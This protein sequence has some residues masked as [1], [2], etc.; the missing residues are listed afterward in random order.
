MGTAA[1]EDQAGTVLNRGFEPE[2][3]LGIPDRGHS[4]N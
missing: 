1:L 2:E 3:E 4:M